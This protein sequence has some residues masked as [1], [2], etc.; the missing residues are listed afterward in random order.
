MRGGGGGRR[1][2]VQGTYVAKGQCRGAAIRVAT[3]TTV[4]WRQQ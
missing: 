4:D 1:G 3:T 2:E